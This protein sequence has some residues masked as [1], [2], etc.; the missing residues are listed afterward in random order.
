M[1]NKIITLYFQSEIFQD[2]ILKYYFFNHSFSLK[3]ALTFNTIRHTRWSIVL[4][5]RTSIM[6]TS[7][8]RIFSSASCVQQRIISERLNQIY[9]AAHRWKE[10]SV[11]CIKL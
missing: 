10:E 11:T 4:I 2:Y 6:V 3:L 7:T 1:N 9:I 8:A 5:P